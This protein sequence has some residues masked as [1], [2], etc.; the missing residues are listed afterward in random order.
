MTEAEKE[1]Q[2]LKRKQELRTR[3]HAAQTRARVAAKR[4]AKAAEFAVRAAAEQRRYEAAM[5][6]KHEG[7]TGINPAT[8]YQRVLLEKLSEAASELIEII[9]L[10]KSGIRDGD[11]FWHASDPLGGTFRNMRKLWE[12]LSRR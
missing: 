3:I 12:Q 11:G 4:Q 7:G 6:E 9:E 1:S 10:E 2:E 5:A 8:G